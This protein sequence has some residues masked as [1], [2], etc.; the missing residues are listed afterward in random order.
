MCVIC[1]C[2]CLAKRLPAGDASGRSRHFTTNPTA[3]CQSR[4]LN[5]MIPLS[6]YQSPD[7]IF[8]A[9]RYHCGNTPTIHL[10]SKHPLPLKGLHLAPSRA[11]SNVSCP[12]RKGK[13]NPQKFLLGSKFSSHF[14][15]SRTTSAPWFPLQLI[16]SLP[17]GQENTCQEIIMK[18]ALQ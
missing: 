11:M 16:F 9:S 10:F 4:G 18:A 7:P 14:Q 3:T 13:T 15:G 8:S 17:H 2:A 12:V 6:R 1:V 5:S